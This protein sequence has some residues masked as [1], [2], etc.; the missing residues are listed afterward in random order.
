MYKNPFENTPIGTKPQPGTYNDPFM[1]GSPYRVQTQNTQAIQPSITPAKTAKVGSFKITTPK[2]N[3]GVPAGQMR[4]APKIEGETPTE[5]FLKFLSPFARA[6]QKAFNVISEAV[7]GGMNRLD[8][9]F[10]VITTKEST[11][12]E[13]VITGTEAV[14]GLGTVAFSPVMA[15]FDAA[16]ELPIIKYAAKPANWALQKLGEAGAWAGGTAVDAINFTLPGNYKLNQGELDRIKPIAQEVGSLFTMI[17]GIELFNRTVKGKKVGPETQKLLDKGR[18]A[19]DTLTPYEKLEFNSVVDSLK[20]DNFYN[21]GIIKTFQ[22]KLGKGIEKLK[23]NG[24]II[25]HENVDKIISDAVKQTELPVN[26][27]EMTIPVINAEP[28]KI[29]TDNKIVL[30][31]LIRNNENI[32]YVKVKTLGNDINGDPIA[33]TFKWDYKKQKATIY[34]T[35]GSTAENI[36]HELGH[37][38]D[39]TTSSSTQRT[40]SEL[41]INKGMK[42]KAIERSLTAYVVKQKGGNISAK[43]ITKGV[44]ETLVK[45]EKDI[46]KLAGPKATPQEKFARAFSKVTTD[47]VGSAKIAP[48][49]SAFVQY[50]LAKEGMPLPKPKLTTMGVTPKGILSPAE[51]KKIGTETIPSDINNFKEDIIST[52][53]ENE[54]VKRGM[55]PTVAESFA[56][57][58]AHYIVVGIENVK[59][60]AQKTKFYIDTVQNW[61]RGTAMKELPGEKQQVSEYLQ[62]RGVTKFREKIIPPRAKELLQEAK[63]HFA[64]ADK[65]SGMFTEQ[66]NVAAQIAMGQ[67]KTDFA[68]EIIDNANGGIKFREAQPFA[69]FQDLSTK[70][71]EKLKGRTT[72]SKQFISDLNKSPDL[73]QVERDIIQ[74]VLDGYGEKIRTDINIGIPGVKVK[75]FTSDQ[76]PVK[77]FADKVKAELLPLKRQDITARLYDWEKKKW[78]SPDINARYEFVALPQESRGNIARYSEIMYESPI[79]T[80]AGKIHF[81][82][83]NYFGHTRIEDMARPRFEG[84]QDLAKDTFRDANTTRRVIEVQSDLYQ[85]GAMAEEVAR[86]GKVKRGMIGAKLEMLPGESAQ[87]FMK[88]RIAYQKSLMGVP[89]KSRLAEIVKL[90]QYNDPTAHFRM[91]R[92]EVKQAAIDGKT[93]LQ[94][95]T[96][97]TAMKIEGLGEVN[98]RG[99]RIPGKGPQGSALMLGPEN[100]NRLKVGME[101]TKSDAGDWIITDILGDGK[102]KAVP[103][104]SLKTSPTDFLEK[105]TLQSVKVGNKEFYYNRSVVQEQFDISGKV[106]TSNPIYQ[107]YEKDLGKYLRNKYGAT[108]ITDNKGVTWNEIAIKPEMAKQPVEAFRMAGLESQLGGKITPEQEKQIKA[109]NK[110]IFGD[111]DVKIVE[112]ILTPEGRNALGSYRENMMKILAGQADAKASFYHETVHKYLDVLTTQAEQV[113]LILE[114]KKRFAATDFKQA[115]E[116]LAEKFIDYAKSR[117]GVAGTLKLMFDKVLVRIKKYLGNADT[118]DTFYTEILAGKVTEGPR[119]GW[120][121]STTGPPLVAGTGLKTG[122]FVEGRPAFNLDKINA[123]Q[124]VEKIIKTIAKESDQFKAQRISKTNADIEKLAFEVGVTPEDLMKTQ[125]GSIA[126]A[127]TVLKARKLVMDLAAD[128]RNTIRETTT[129]IATPEQLKTLRAKI[130]RLQGTMKAVAGLRTE[131]SNVF[132]QFQI[133]AAIGENDIMRNLLSELKVVDAE[134]AGDLAKFSKKVKE[135]LEPTIADK[136]WHLWYMNILSGVSTQIKNVFGNITNMGAEIARVAITQP[137]ELPKAL[138]GLYQGLIKGRDMAA[139]VLKEGEITK[140]EEKGIKPIVFT[141]ETPVG[142][143]I[144]TGLN[145]LDYVGRFMSAADALFREGFRGMEL[146]GQA[147]EMAM[148]EGLTGEALNKRIIDLIAD[149][150]Q[151]MIESADQFAKRGVYTQKP[152]GLMGWFSG[153][154]S[155][156]TTV[157]ATDPFGR[158]VIKGIART[159]VPFT[160]IVANVVNNGLDW[161]PAGFGREGMIKNLW[162]RKALSRVQYQELGRATMGTIA[163]TYLASL[164]A[165]G[166]ISGSGPTEKKEREILIDSGWRQNSIKIGDT[167][168]PYSNWGPLTIPMALVANYNDAMKYGNMTNKDTFERTTAAVLNT[169]QSILDM[170]FLNGLSDLIVAVKDKDPTY[171]KRYIASQVTT[172][173]PNLFKQVARFFDTTQYEANTIQEYILSNLRITSGL[174]PRLNVFGDVVKGEELTQLQPVRETSDPTI[175]YLAEKELWIS[176]PS[177]ATMVVDR[178]TGEKRQMTPDEYYEYVEISGKAI[179]EVLDRDLGYIKTM[180]AY[181]EKQ[182]DFIDKMVQKERDRAKMMIQ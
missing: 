160:R 146:Y 72:V 99:W 107:F 39:H 117:E 103:K 94:F 1:E 85:K 109:L 41:M 167:W 70:L 38:F 17:K 165:N 118:I 35:N 48:E 95:P 182:K 6:G 173:V 32:D 37:Y 116:I 61:L 78:K 134:S 142:K 175:K 36:A 174:K 49:F 67:A 7:T 98:P 30:Q 52:R 129:E 158:K 87:E 171:F 176:I 53:I 164:A 156:G 141:G 21:K 130:F 16:E 77:E 120:G 119:A 27:G 43:E 106:D 169:V 58:L 42:P 145:S 113:D 104:E 62:K 80:S 64:K 93:K 153:M 84:A 44:K 179:K 63:E 46:Q 11:V 13:Q 132:R 75:E 102:F 4:T 90:Q 125:P 111:E 71:L 5:G 83:E 137:T 92:E 54:L 47:P 97:E 3:F 55:D 123:P 14:M 110:K 140:F 105:S 26:P 121:V 157:K 22:E 172:P 25:T 40:L 135:V 155:G 2:I 20:A 127:E 161:T 101:L 24:E 68:Y 168:Y 51:A 74:N 29:A 181:P 177:K 151:E 8:K 159:I 28:I 178:N 148:K 82:G 76:I 112:Q 10:E 122:R 59:G 131:A 66:K 69:G 143:A 163:M 50:A 73:K 152:T 56:G 149:P 88:R 144:A 57:E 139:K 31:K 115:E 147:R 154:I 166:L 150:L 65:E 19:P 170:S 89:E 108:T 180:E 9:F 138:E 136:A 81:G 86:V 133:E 18:E 45:M 34:V 128:L 162:E 60:T 79:K 12:A 33:S 114:A 15:M 91:V 23:A 96:G 126:N 124:D 100:A